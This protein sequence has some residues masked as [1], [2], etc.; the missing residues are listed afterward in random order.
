MGVPIWR[1]P[2]E[3]A[4]ISQLPKRPRIEQGVDLW[5]IYTWEDSNNS[6][7]NNDSVDPQQEDNSED[8]EQTNSGDEEREAPL[9]SESIR[10]L[11][12][13]DLGDDHHEV[14]EEEGVG[15]PMSSVSSSSSWNHNTFEMQP[16][17][18]LPTLR[19]GS[20]FRSTALPIRATP[21]GFANYTDTQRQLDATTN[22]LP[23]GRAPDN[24]RDTGD[25]L[26]LSVYNDAT[27]PDN[28][29]H[30][31]FTELAYTSSNPFHESYMRESSGR[32]NSTD[33]A[34]EHDIL[35][36]TNSLDRGPL[37]DRASTSERGPLFGQ[38]RTP[39]GGLFAP[40]RTA[41][42]TATFSQE[43]N[44][45]GS[46]SLSDHLN[47]IGFM[48]DNP[49]LAPF[50]MPSTRPRTLLSQQQNSRP[51][52]PTLTSERHGVNSRQPML[53]GFKKGEAGPR[54]A[55]L[56][57]RRFAPGI[58]PGHK[59]RL[60]GAVPL[61]STTPTDGLANEDNED[62]LAGAWQFAGPEI[63]APQR[64][65]PSV[66][67][68]FSPQQRM[69]PVVPQSR[70]RLSRQVRFNNEVPPRPPPRETDRQPSTLHQDRRPWP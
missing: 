45:Y 43:Q 17:G 18:L 47:R 15:S 21:Y 26:M 32:Q 53:R 27:N 2:Q 8:P 61:P 5:R 19:T 14:V 29:P 30:M 36:Q 41:S 44:E 64:R 20:V 66:N 1:A 33:Y 16:R 42:N 70:R 46:D 23:W 62:D 60:F 11:D 35:D 7:I 58:V 40:A 9:A 12:L 65:L 59:R 4:D 49:H 22:Q 57:R 54:M 31:E 13:L 50:A 48:M 69:H 37:L 24:G 6:S 38:T 63:T 51:L 25:N 67:G 55:W 3:P 68:L 52:A 28:F 10:L 34:L 39:E 56:S